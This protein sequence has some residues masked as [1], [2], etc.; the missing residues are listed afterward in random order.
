MARI[1]STGGATFSLH[2]DKAKMMGTMAKIPKIALGKSNLIAFILLRIVDVKVSRVSVTGPTVCRAS[3]VLYD[4][5]RLLI[6]L[7]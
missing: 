6:Q 3:G 1:R 5:Q 4:I 2:A 7:D